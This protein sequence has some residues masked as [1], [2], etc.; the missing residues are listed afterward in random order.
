MTQHT[1]AAVPG[2]AAELAE[3]TRLVEDDEH[4]TVAGRF[5]DHLVR[6]V[7][8]CDLAFLAITGDDGFEIA[9]TTGQAPLTPLS[10]DGAAGDGVVHDDPIRE[11]LRY[12]EPRRLGDTAE[13]RRWPLFASRLALHGYR[14]CLVLPLPTERSPTAALTLL[15]REAHRFNDHSY[16]VILLIALH[17]GV[18]LDNIDLVHHSRQ[19]VRHLTTALDTRHTI[20]L[21]QGLL[22][23]HFSCDTDGGFTL[24]RT[25]SQH[26]NRKLRDVATDLVEAHERGE[27]A[28]ALA[29]HRLTG[30]GAPKPDG[31]PT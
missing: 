12:R 9:V 15:S 5:A 10:K 6:T 27:L 16:D 29:L 26:T 21:A 20:G 22:M 23:R 4:Q 8:G 7:P 19:M 17:A 1:D 30:D 18:A 28:K 25:A 11:V 2:L 31:V 14:S 24:L 3:M 13:D